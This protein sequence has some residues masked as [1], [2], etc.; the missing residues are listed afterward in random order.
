M[1]HYL[2]NWF[3]DYITITWSTY[4]C[5]RFV[6]QR[7]KE[8]L[9]LERKRDVFASEFKQRGRS[10][11]SFLEKWT[12]SHINSL[13]IT[14]LLSLSNVDSEVSYWARSKWLELQV[15]ET[16]KF[17]NGRCAESPRN[18][19]CL[20]VYK[21][22]LPPPPFNIITANGNLKSMLAQSWCNYYFRH[23]WELAYGNSYFHL[24]WVICI[25]ANVIKYFSMIQCWNNKL[26]CSRRNMETRAVG[27]EFYI[28]EPS[29]H[30]KVM[31]MI[32]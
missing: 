21:A 3:E 29:I 32:L 27:H 24:N 4:L 12:S 8:S 9:S 10:W 28:N 6:R 13:L 1:A 25:V 18:Q 5:H 20:V 7:A 11:M 16:K 23:I 19:P 15:E 31:N 17:W 14:P 26:F 2:S 30:Q 22:C